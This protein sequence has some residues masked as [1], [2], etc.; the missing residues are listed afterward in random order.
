LMI[1]KKKRRKKKRKKKK[2]NKKIGRSPCPHAPR[3]VIDEARKVGNVGLGRVLTARRAVKKAVQLLDDR[4]RREH[5][6]KIMR[7]HRDV[8][9]GSE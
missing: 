6:G 7:E 3:V 9:A 2:K 4:V 8:P 1:Q 5:L